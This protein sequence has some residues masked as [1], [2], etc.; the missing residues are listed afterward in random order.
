[1]TEILFN[2]QSG[3]L[4]MEEASMNARRSFKI[5]WRELSWEM[6]R[7]IPVHNLCAVKKAF[8]TSK[9]TENN[10]SVEHMWVGDMTFDGQII[11]GQL[12]NQPDEIDNLNQGDTVKFHYEE[13]SDW[14]CSIRGKVYGAFTVNIFRS[15]MTKKELEAHDNAWEMDFGDPKP[16]YIEDMLSFTE[17]LITLSSKLPEHSMSKNMADKSEEGIKAMGVRINE[18]SIFGMTMLQFES[19]AGNL[20]QVKLLIKYGADQKIKN[21]HGQTATNLAEMFNWSEIVTVLQ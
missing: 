11:T 1:M 14:M 8:F 7:I 2:A 16:V 21:I 3:D 17:F 10:V 5:I 9:S 6:R 20:T 4:E 15:R 12:L 18:P 19:L 13:I